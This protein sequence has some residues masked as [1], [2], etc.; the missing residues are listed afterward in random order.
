M[1]SGQRSKSKLKN[2]PSYKRAR[3]L[4][5]RRMKAKKKAA[6]KRGLN[7]SKKRRTAKGAR[8]KKK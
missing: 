7:R 5:D 2:R 4:K 6:H 1:A 8:S 3:S